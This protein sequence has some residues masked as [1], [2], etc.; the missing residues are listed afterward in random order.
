MD[1]KLN[2]LV[3]KTLSTNKIFFFTILSYISSVKAFK[4]FF[5]VS[6]THGNLNNDNNF[7]QH[8]KQLTLALI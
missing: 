7:R 1:K 4:N 6:K 3:L 5:S 8:T 2:T